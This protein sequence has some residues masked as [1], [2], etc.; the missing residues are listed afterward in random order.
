M[1]EADWRDDSDRASSH[2]PRVPSGHPAS[3]QQWSGHSVTWGTEHS[4]EDSQ[5]SHYN[6]GWDSSEGR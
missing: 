1:Y 5:V 4:R 6:A 3:W 2:D